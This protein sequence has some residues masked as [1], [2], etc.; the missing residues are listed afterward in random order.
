SLLVKNYSFQYE[1]AIGRKT[2]VALGYRFMPNSTL[3]FISSI[4]STINDP[5]TEKQV[6]D[7]TTSNSAF[8]P[9][10]RFYLGKK[11][12][13]HGFYLAPFARISQ[14]KASMP[15]FNYKV[16]STDRTI[17]M[18]GKLNTTTGG[19]LMGA[20]WS[21]GKTI[22]LDWWILGLNGGSSNGF[23]EG[24]QSLSPM[25][26]DAFRQALK[27]LEIP[28]T[29]TTVTVDANGGRLDMKGSWAGLR[30]GGLCIGIRF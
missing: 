6:D 25:E 13:F 28:F 9:E 2:S 14:Y 20:Q 7:L 8:T 5:D 18:N 21:L 4:K 19:L 23:I 12:V 22:Y 16:A 29:K 15:H 11:G 30:G 17:A 24:K 27:D 1:L 10:I 26:Q 3:P